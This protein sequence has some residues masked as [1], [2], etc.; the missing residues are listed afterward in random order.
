M[1]KMKAYV[2]NDA[3]SNAIELAEVPI[4]EVGESE[5]LVEVRAFGVGVHDRYFIPSHAN[6]P[7]PIG[8]EA[9]GIITSIGSKVTDFKVGDRVIFSSSLQPQGGPWAQ[10]A[11]VPKSSLIPMPEKL[12]FV[13]GAAIPVA[14]RAALESIGTLDLK[15]NDTLFIAGA[16]GAIGT[17]VIQLAVARGIRVAGSASRK[18]HAYMLSL[19]AEVVVDYCAPDWKRVVTQWGQSGVDAALAVQPGTADDCMDVVK[20]GG[21]VVTVSGD[22]V[23]PKRNITVQQIMHQ[24][25]TQLELVN[26]VSD[27]AAAQIRLVIEHVYSFEQAIDALEKT[28]A[29]HARG[30]VVVEI[31]G[32]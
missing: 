3:A 16:S 10:Y 6:F 9:S 20:D 14:G 12:S 11:V 7:Y 30:K 29:R 15:K 21:K 24:E 32:A 13:E 2:R 8:T 19:G 5:V 23:A 31:S 17:L 27:I 28:E 4:P 18:N 25:K 26:L 1:K 22:R